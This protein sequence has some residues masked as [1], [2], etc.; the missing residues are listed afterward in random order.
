MS[1]NFNKIVATTEATTETT[2]SLHLLTEQMT[3]AVTDISEKIEEFK[4]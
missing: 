4:V 3:S 1:E 2:D